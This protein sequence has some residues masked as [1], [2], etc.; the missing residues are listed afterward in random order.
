MKIKNTEESSGDVI[1]SNRRK[2]IKN[3]LPWILGVCLL[4]ILWSYD[5]PRIHIV[6]FVHVLGMVKI[7][8]FISGRVCFQSHI[9]ERAVHALWVRTGSWC[10]ES[11]LSVGMQSVCSVIPT[12]WTTGH[13]LGKFYLSVGMQ[14]VYSTVPAQPTGPRIFIYFSSFIRAV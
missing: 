11:N 8:L 13:L 10:H 14:S 3:C 1:W 4:D 2:T 9:D 12:N 6:S 5:N 7:I